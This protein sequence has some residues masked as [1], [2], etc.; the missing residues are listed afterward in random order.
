MTK[1]ASWPQAKWLTEGTPSEVR[2]K[3]SGLVHRVPAVN[4]APV[5]VVYDV[6]GRDRTQYPS[7]GA[8]S[9]AAYGSGSTPFASGIENSPGAGREGV[10]LSQS[11][12]LPART[13]DQGR[14]PGPGGPGP[15]PAQARIAW[16][17][18]A[19]V[20]QARLQAAARGRMWG[21]PPRAPPGRHHEARHV[22]RPPR[23]DRAGRR[24]RRRPARR[25]RS[26]TAASRR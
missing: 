23:S 5:L 1:L 18:T 22:R 3:V 21:Q 6:P 24:V 2:S 13:Q 25:A 17:A 8:A 10:R 26:S 4:R 14:D 19:D 15:Q 16:R 7:G 11:P 12:L 20:R 9:S